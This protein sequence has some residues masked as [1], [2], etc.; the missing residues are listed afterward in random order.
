MGSERERESKDIGVCSS[1][2]RLRCPWGQQE[3][4][5]QNSEVR[6][7]NF[8]RITGDFAELAVTQEST[9]LADTK[10]KARTHLQWYR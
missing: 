3:K 6:E 9:K 1:Q 8:L 2:K 7:R 10:P 5:R 4:D